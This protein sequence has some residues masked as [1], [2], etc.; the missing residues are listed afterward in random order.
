MFSKKRFDFV[1]WTKQAKSHNQAKSGTQIHLISAS[2][3][4][5]PA[6]RKCFC[7]RWRPL[8]GESH[9]GI[10]LIRN[11][12]PPLIKSEEAKRKGMDVSLFKRLSE[13]HPN[14]V[15]NLEYQVSA[16]K[17]ISLNIHSTG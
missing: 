1:S 2:V 9:S 15:V 11:Q 13:A 6:I 12:L 7:S 5:T 10:R 17:S 16:R 3:S 8:S 14:A 4:G